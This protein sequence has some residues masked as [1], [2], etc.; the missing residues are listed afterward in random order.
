MLIRRLHAVAGSHPA[1]NTRLPV[2]R[3]LAVR[4]HPPP[5]AWRPLRRARWRIR[6]RS[7][8]AT[9]RHRLG[10]ATAPAACALCKRTARGNSKAPR[11]SQVRHV[12][13]GHRRMRA[14]SMMMMDPGSAPTGAVE[15][16]APVVRHPSD[17]RHIPTMQSGGPDTSACSRQRKDART[18]PAAREPYTSHGL[19]CSNYLAAAA[20][21]SSNNRCNA[22][23]LGLHGLAQHVGVFPI[24]RWAAHESRL[25]HPRVYWPHVNGSARNPS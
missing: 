18:S 24:P 25:G 8:G 1:P 17:R 19:G 13:S 14:R 6:P 20:S 16:L 9:T 22:E 21:G 2:P 12:G 3:R 4:S 7:C 5:S 23:E 11:A 10:G 15:P